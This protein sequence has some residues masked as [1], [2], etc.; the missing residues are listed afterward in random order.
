MLCHPERSEGSRAGTENYT[1][2][3]VARI[4]ANAQKRSSLAVSAYAR[5]FVGRQGCMRMIKGG[6]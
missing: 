4:F 1:A 3:D 2:R 5:F 6:F